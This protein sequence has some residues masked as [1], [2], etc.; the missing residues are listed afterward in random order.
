MADKSKV[1]DV[2]AL[3]ALLAIVN[4][5][6]GLKVNTADIVDSLLSQDATKVL[7]ANQGYVIKQL[8]DAKQDIIQYSTMP[9]ASADLLGTIVQYIG[10]DSQAYKGGYWYKCVSDGEVTPTYS[11][12]LIKYSADVDMALNPA[13][14]N[15]VAN[16]VLTPALAEK[17]TQ[18]DTLPAA[19]ADLVGEIVQYTGGTAENLNHG[20]F[21]QCVS[22]GEPTPTYSWQNVS[23][24]EPTE[25]A[26]AS[27]VGV[28]KPGD[29]LNVDN[30]GS[31]SVVNRLQEIAALPTAT[32]DNLNKCYLLTADQAGYT[33]GGTYQCQVVPESDPAT[34]E[35][36][37]ISAADV[38]LSSY[39]TSWTGTIEDWEA[40][41]AATKALYSIVFITNDGMGLSVDTSYIV[42]GG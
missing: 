17:L 30:T 40:L 4:T 12:Q 23:V 29:G 25:I 31:L 26:T 28:V 37:L 22:D 14:N 35:W 10:A 33:K 41:P 2:A 5:S 11:W 34:Y 24:Q 36:V 8:I 7:S 19:S 1:P 18:L 15:P 9:V 32:V 13:S 20:W 38:D 27:T 6:L 21:Y 3:D 42:I 39:Q 16:S